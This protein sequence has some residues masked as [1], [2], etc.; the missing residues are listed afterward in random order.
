MAGIWKIGNHI[1]IQGMNNDF[2]ILSYS[3]IF[4]GCVEMTLESTEG[5]R[6]FLK[7]RKSEIY[8]IEDQY[9][10]ADN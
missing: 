9:A 7:R 8:G 6:Y 1:K 3:F 10:F 5:G 2:K 4:G